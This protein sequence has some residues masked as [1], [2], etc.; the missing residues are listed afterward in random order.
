[1]YR[2]GANFKD[3]QAAQKWA[4]DKAKYNSKIEKIVGGWRVTWDVK[5]I[6]NEK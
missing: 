3:E 4:K 2:I 1:M 5:P 6:K